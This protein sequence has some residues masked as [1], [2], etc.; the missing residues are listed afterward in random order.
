MAY[1]IAVPVALAVAAYRQEP[2]LAVA[3]RAASAALAH[4]ADYW[5]AAADDSDDSLPSSFS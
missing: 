4:A 3:V 5:Q 2:A 1:G